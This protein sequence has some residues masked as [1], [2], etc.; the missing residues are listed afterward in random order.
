MED[1]LPVGFSSHCHGKRQRIT[2]FNQY[3]ITRGEI[4]G[5]RMQI[6]LPA[7]L[8]WRERNQRLISE[9]CGWEKWQYL[10]V[11]SCLAVLYVYYC[12]WACACQNV[13]LTLFVQC[14]TMQILQPYRSG[15]CKSFVFIPDGNDAE[16]FA[17]F[18]SFGNALTQAHPR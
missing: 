6:W 4:G 18:F 15:L 17:I 2:G 9:N 7:A 10:F 13:G 5:R 12:V 8:I 3:M 14:C 16:V 11:M 1:A